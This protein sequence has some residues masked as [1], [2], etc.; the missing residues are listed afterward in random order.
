MEL[1]ID[2]RPFSGLDKGIYN[3]HVFRVFANPATKSHKASLST[4]ANLDSSAIRWNIKENG[5][6]YEVSMLIP[7]KSLKL[8]APADLA[9]DIAVND[10][11]ENKRISSIPWSGNDD[12]H[13]HRFNFGTLIIK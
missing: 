5:A 6:D 11:D 4:S 1:F 13:K 8:N 2:S 12:N 10:S 9:F 7:W 3:D